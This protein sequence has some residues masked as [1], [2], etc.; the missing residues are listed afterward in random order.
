[1]CKVE[2]WLQNLIVRC[3]TGLKPGAL[4]QVRRGDFYLLS[5]IKNGKI[6]GLKFMKNKEKFYKYEAVLKTEDLEGAK[7]WKYNN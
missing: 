4:V 7:I 1:M 6:Y 5:Y 2:G 3:R